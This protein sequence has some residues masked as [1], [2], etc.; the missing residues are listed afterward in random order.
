MTTCI[1][2]TLEG[3]YQLQERVDRR[4]IEA[5]DW[6]VVGGLLSKLIERTESRIARLK[7]KADHQQ[8]PQESQQNET[9][10]THGAEPSS[11]AEDGA[12]NQESDE[13]DPSNEADAGQGEPAGAEPTEP[14][15]PK[16]GHG[17]NGANAFRNAT[18]VF[19]ALAAGIIGGICILCGV[20]RVFPYRDKVIIRVVGQSLFA[21]FRHHFEQGRCRLCGAI[22]TAEGIQLVVREGIGTS[23]ITYDWS[24]CAIL[25]VMHYFA[26]APFKRLEALHQGWGV[27]MPDANQWRV[28]DECDDLLAPLSRALEKHAIQ[29]AITLI[30]D[31]TGSMIIEIRRQIQKEIQVLE[32]LG[33][34]TKHVRT[35]I[36]ASCIR[37]ETEAAKIVLFYTGRH[38]AAEM[39]DRLLEHRRASAEK[40]VAVSDAASKNFSHGHADE[41]E[42]AVCN[43]HCYLKFR[44]VKNQFPAEHAV[45]GEVYQDVF[46]ND[47]KTEALGLDPHARMLYHRE[48]SKPHMVR[49]WQMCKDKVDGKL[50]E[51]NS[52]LWEPVSFVINQWPRLTR[53]YEVPG[54]PLD[55]NLVEQALIIPVRYLAGSFAYQTQTGAD[56]GDR[57]MSL[58]AT[59]NVNGVEPVAYLTECLR[60]H[61]DLAKRSE[62]YLP[63]VYR[64]RLEQLDCVPQAQ[65]PPPSR[66]S[67]PAEQ[68]VRHPLRPGT[69]RP[70]APS[71]P[72]QP[73]P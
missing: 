38:H 8:P 28:V 26:G 66:P 15:P 18:K 21:A 45:A 22:F 2:V 24:A 63:W 3:L 34:S 62:Y 68:E 23:Y 4:Q 41:L 51:P 29:H 46:A 49:L 59:A 40:L 52:P 6:P 70:S 10:P 7:A 57:H 72:A 53:F 65:G 37:I 12:A 58:I 73:P 17:R 69:H 19:H 32:L 67:P 56:V 11:H 61:E 64:D 60:N 25:I 43:A 14:D 47:D 35:G 16:K 36:N 20:G 27:P 55:S 42:Q 31:D 54:V 30:F 44:A 48:H 13:D 9:V 71:A 1:D 50:V 39:V 33:E 5:E